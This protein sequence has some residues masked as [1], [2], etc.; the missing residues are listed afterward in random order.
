MASDPDPTWWRNGTVYQ[1]YPSSFKDSNGDGLGDIPGIISKLDYLK[2]LG[3]DIIW[4]SPHYD[5]PQVD[6]GYDIS[7]YESVY[8]PFGTMADMDALIRGCHDRGLRIIVDLVVN[9]TSDQ[10]A[11]FKESRSSK[12]NNPKRDWYIW[13]PAKFDQDGKRQPPNNWRALFGGSAWEWDEPT[14]EYFLHLFCPE[15]PDLNWENEETRNGIYESAVAFW[16]K[17]GVDG[18][19]IDTVNLYS[20]DQSFP[21]AP[22]LDPDTVLQTVIYTV[23][24]GP[25]MH[26]FL[27]EMNDKHL[28][29]Y[30]ILSILSIPLPREKILHL[31]DL[32]VHRLLHFGSNINLPYLY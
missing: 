14:Q 31:N 18:F 6:M 17:K 1:I 13:R 4:L 2:D 24:N 10:H 3:I 28:S 22:I 21:D 19:R 12:D 7:D 23:P 26:E 27:R 15:Q 20:K 32:C 8:P 16:L 11:W 25:R 5:G 29:K 30:T 9:H